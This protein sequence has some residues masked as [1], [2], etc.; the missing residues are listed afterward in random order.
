M[1]G[2]AALR[3]EKGQIEGKIAHFAFYPRDNFH[4]LSHAYLP[5]IKKT[6]SSSSKTALGSHANIAGIQLWG[7][8][9]ENDN[10]IIEASFWTAHSI[11]DKPSAFYFPC[12]KLSKK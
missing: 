10:S 9:G 12:L 6:L 1:N 5:T 4:L 7:K 8:R 11:S 2:S 3:M